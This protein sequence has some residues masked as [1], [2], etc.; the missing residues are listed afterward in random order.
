MRCKEEGGQGR[1]TLPETLSTTFPP[2]LSIN[3]S[4]SFLDFESFPCEYKKEIMVM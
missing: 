1:H 3:F 2:R 4:I